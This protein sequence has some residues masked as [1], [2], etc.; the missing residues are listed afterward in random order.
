ML[1]ASPVLDTEDTSVNTEDTSV[2]KTD[3]DL[4]PRGATILDGE[5]IMNMV[6]V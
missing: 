1:L 4:C 5:Q 6:K 2:N 3:K